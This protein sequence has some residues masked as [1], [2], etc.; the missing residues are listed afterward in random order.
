MADFFILS[1]V[2]YLSFRFDLLLFCLGNEETRLHIV[3][4]VD[5]I[6]LPNVHHHR[7]TKSYF[8]FSL[9]ANEKNKLDKMVWCMCWEKGCC[10][11]KRRHVFIQIRSGFKDL[12]TLAWFN[13]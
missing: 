9:L 10:R 1:V 2:P 3:Y 5:C 7:D 11:N 8:D 4:T 6:D 13:K 12:N